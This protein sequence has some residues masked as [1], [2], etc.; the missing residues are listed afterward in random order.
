M[1]RKLTI[2]LFGATGKTGS[3]FLKK[4]LNAGYR[5]KV[6][7]RNKNKLAEKNESLFV[8]EGDILNPEDVNR[9]VE[10]A[11]VVVS[12]FGHVKGSSKWLQTRGTKNIIDSMKKHG[13]DKIISLSGG[14]LPFHLD[15]PKIPDYLIRIIM[16]IAVPKVL[17]DAIE[18][19]KVLERSGVKYIIVRGPVLTEEPERGSYRVGW[20]GVNAGTKIGR[21]DLADF[22]INQ[23]EDD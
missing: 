23:V 4:A 21:D 2:S 14:G 7:V 6:L 8:L 13:L 16:K 10:G 12:L 11:D 17:N 9:A 19:A 22:I 1:E 15:K 18:H 5:V 20:V 3:R